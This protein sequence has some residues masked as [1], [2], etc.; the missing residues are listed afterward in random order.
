MSQTQKK[1]NN[2]RIKEAQSPSKSSCD[3]TDGGSLRGLAKEKLQKC[4][5][6]YYYMG[7]LWPCA[8]LYNFIC[9][10]FF[11]FCC[12]FVLFSVCCIVQAVT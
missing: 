4:E 8:A 11:F 2:L 5:K 3:L 7:Y 6:Y 1:K 12:C 9:I 10:V